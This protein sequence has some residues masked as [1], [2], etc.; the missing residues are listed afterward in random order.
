[1]KTKKKKNQKTTSHEKI[2]TY[3]TSQPATAYRASLSPLPS[4][5]DF[6]RLSVFR[7]RVF[8]LSNSAWKVVRKRRISVLQKI[9]SRSDRHQAPS[10]IHAHKKVGEEK[11]Y[12]RTY[13]FIS[14]HDC[15][16]S[17]S[18]SDDSNICTHL[19]PQSSLYDG[20]RLVI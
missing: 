13:N 14:I 8:G 5:I 12:N 10:T 19:V 18:N 6:K 17:M 7:S 20:I 2:R 3:H 16:Q 1:M 4:T 11:V 9:N 15:L